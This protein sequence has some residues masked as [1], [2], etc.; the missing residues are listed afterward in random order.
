MRVAIIYRQGSAA[1]PEVGPMLIGALGQ[2]VE[3]Y[4]ERF[5]TF[6]FFVAGGGLVVADFDDTR[7]LQRVVAENPFTPYMNV[8]IQP[9]VEPG[10][11]IAIYTDTIAAALAGAADPVA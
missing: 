3:R 4:Q 7:E 2:W 11:A 8:E 1:P 10:A 5:S 9:V 6:E